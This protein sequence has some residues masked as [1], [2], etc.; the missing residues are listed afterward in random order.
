VTR[1]NPSIRKIQARDIL[2]AI[3]D[4]TN[5]VLQWLTRHW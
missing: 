4:P 5:G 3:E 2:A 1:Y